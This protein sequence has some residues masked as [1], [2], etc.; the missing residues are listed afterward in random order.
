MIIG[1]ILQ[2]TSYSYAQMVVARIITGAS[3]IRSKNQELSFLRFS[4][5]RE[6]FKRAFPVPTWPIITQSYYRLQQ[7]PPTM[8][9]VLLQLSGELSS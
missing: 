9:N 7:S 4:R 3:K 2:T 6:R 8:Q 1:A 5:P